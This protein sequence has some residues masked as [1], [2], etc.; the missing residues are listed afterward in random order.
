VDKKYLFKNLKLTVKDREL[1]PITDEEINEEIRTLV[2]W[3]ANLSRLLEVDPQLTVELTLDGKTLA[4]RLKR[5]S[6]DEGSFW[7]AFHEHMDSLL[8]EDLKRRGISLDKLHYGIA[9][10]GD[11]EYAYSH[12]PPADYDALRSQA[13]KNWY[14]VVAILPPYRM[15]LH[16]NIFYVPGGRLHEFLDRKIY[17]QDDRYNR[18]VHIQP[19]SEEEYRKE[20]ADARAKVEEYKR[21]KYRAQ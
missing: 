19:L 13:E 6:R 14:K 8:F 15:G 17:A 16:R 20:I 7:F 18:I 1:L 5:F 11:V 10:V 21:Q 9:K 12:V 2:D 4:Q 3:K